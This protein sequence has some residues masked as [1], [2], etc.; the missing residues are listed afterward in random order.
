ME[1]YILLFTLLILTLIG[2][3]TNGKYWTMTLIIFIFSAIRYRIGYDY[4]AYEN[5]IINSVNDT[6]L[7]HRLDEL[8]FFPK[9]LIFLS[10][11]TDV[12]LF[13]IISSGVITYIFAYNIKKYSNNPR[14]SLF[15][16][17]C[18]P[19]MMIDYFAII[20]N[21]MAYA[22]VLSAIVNQQNK[23]KQ[24]IFIFIASLCHV[25]ALMT[26]IIL[27]PWNKIKAKYLWLMLGLSFFGSKLLLS[28]LYL[29]SYVNNYA[30]NQLSLYTSGDVD[31]QGGN[32]MRYFIIGLAL[33]TLL[34]Y[35]KLTKESSKYAYYISLICLGASL[36]IMLIDFSHVAYRLSIYFYSPLLILIPDLMKSYKVSKPLFIISSILLFAVYVLNMHLG[37]KS[38]ITNESSVYPYKTL[39]DK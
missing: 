32:F 11:Q 16:F 21:A 29:L 20:R 19:F 23:K 26:I 35:K 9:Y 30:A 6:Y 8:E 31:M 2:R 3:Q 17:V 25:S 13:F 39:F 38:K 7:S 12:S 5:L 10:Q 34:N 37:T 18:L 14:Y 1:G 22:F 15:L 24:L 33:I 36:Y 28:S 27:F 4:S